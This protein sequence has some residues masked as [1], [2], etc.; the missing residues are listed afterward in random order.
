M[1]NGIMLQSFEWYL[2]PDGTLWR[3]LAREAFHLRELGFTALWLPPA[4]KGSGGR[5]DVGYGVYD[6]YDLGEF[7]QKGTVATKYGTAAEYLRAIRAIHRAGAQALPDVVLNHRMGGDEMEQVPVCCEDFERRNDDSA[8]VRTAGLMTRLTFPGRGGRYSD[9]IWDASCFTGTD[10]DALRKERGLYR[11][12]GKRWA[13]DVDREHGNYDYLMGLDVDV[14]APQVRQE[15]QRW[16]LWFVRRTG[17]DGFRLDAVKH[18]SAGFFR[19]WLDALRRETGRELFSVGEYWHHDAG[20][21]TG[22]LDTVGERMSLFD[23]P[24]HFHLREAGCNRFY[25]MAHLFDGTLVGCRPHLAVTFVDNHDTQPGQALESWVSGWFKP[26][27]YGLI[28]LRAFGYPCVFWGDLMGIP[29]NEFGP[30][31]ALPLLLRL[32]RLNA[33]GE[34]RDYFDDADVI[35]FTRSGDA[36]HPGSGLVF[37]CTNALAGDKRMQV[38]SRLA[39]RH[40]RCVLGGGAD[41]QVDGEGWGT[42]HVDEQQTCVWVPDVTGSERMARLLSEARR[43]AELAARRA[44]FLVESALRGEKL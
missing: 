39:G 38:G 43:K 17:C 1:Q 20:V 28:L 25:D 9:F 16:G 14:Q 7:D 22:Y 11:I 36:A 18:I 10:W 15:L 6:L 3:T 40:F 5:N 29:H 19:E 8:P 33:F 27:A 24:L 21:L 2:P 23:V 41:V 26:A 34:E 30:V 31:S 35:G 37:L 12:Q 32:R 13:D 4:G 44:G 42:F